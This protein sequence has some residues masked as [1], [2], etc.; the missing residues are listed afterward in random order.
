MYEIIDTHCHLDMKEFDNDRDEVIKRSRED[1]VKAI[2][3]P[4]TVEEDFEN[5]KSLCDRYDLLFYMVGIHPHDAKT[6]N[7][8]TFDLAQEHLK[9]EKC[10][11]VGEIGLDYHYDLS[12]RNKQ[13]NVFSDFLDMAIESDVPVSIH[14]RDADDDMVEILRSKKELKGVIHCFSG[15]EKLLKIGLDLGLYFGIG[16]VLTFKNSALKEVIKDV[17]LELVVFETDAPYLAP[18]PKRGKRN[19]P[20]YIKYVIEKMAEILNREPHG[21]S[22][23]AFE[24]SKRVFSLDRI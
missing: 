9:N 17:P 19:E 1:G 23:I 14:C 18:V 10:V 8:E 13:R 6:A 11:G 16:G 21:I 3:I 5:E 15:S 7:G 2:I 12:P 22:K 20:I 4:S 24:N